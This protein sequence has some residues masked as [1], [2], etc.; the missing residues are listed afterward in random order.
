MASK[1][2]VVLS[3]QLFTVKSIFGPYSSHKE[4]SLARDMLVEL[5]LASDDDLQVMDVCKITFPQQPV[6][7]NGLC[8]NREDHEPHQC[9]TGSLGTIWCT[10]NQDDREPNRSERARD[11]LRRRSQQE[12]TSGDS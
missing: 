8:A 9:E 12:G 6:L 3:G 1:Y 2:V 11:A 10:A 7:S 5:R 4:A